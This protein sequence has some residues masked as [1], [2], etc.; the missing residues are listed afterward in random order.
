MSTQR[1][2]QQPAVRA[3]MYARVSCEQQTQQS[4]VANEMSAS[5]QRAAIEASSL[6]A[7]A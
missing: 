7:A 4:T 2:K 1:V 6:G 3:A 5:M